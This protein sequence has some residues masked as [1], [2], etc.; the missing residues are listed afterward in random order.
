MVFTPSDKVLFHM[1]RWIFKSQ[2]RHKLKPLRY[3]LYIVLQQIWNNAHRLDFP[4]Q[5]GI[6]DVMNVN[7]LKHY[8]P[9]LLEDNVTISHPV[10]LIPN[11]QP[12]LLQDTRHTTTRHQQHTSY[13]SGLFS[14]WNESRDITMKYT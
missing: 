5:L 6:H 11:F 1:E 14:E 9:P 2:R 4:P 8:E 13:W 10:E 3:G 12:P 7:N